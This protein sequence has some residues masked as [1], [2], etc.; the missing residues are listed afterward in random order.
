MKR[1]KY[2]S[3]H[4][5]AYRRAPRVCKEMYARLPLSFALF[6]SLV[7]VCLL[8][9]R[10]Q[11]LC[12]RH[13]A[14]TRRKSLSVGKVQFCRGQVRTAVYDCISS[15]FVDSFNFQGFNFQVYREHI[16]LI[17]YNDAGRSRKQHS[18][19]SCQPQRLN[20]ATIAKYD[21]LLTLSLAMLAGYCA[22]A[23]SVRFMDPILVTALKMQDLLI[24]MR[25]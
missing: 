12:N 3:D 6:S 8:V 5:Q 2:R 18:S 24:K 15:V 20:I 7:A 10:V 22:C 16:W 21:T 17:T 9:A 11:V 14:S 13:P 23:L 4:W 19:L 1:K 25:G